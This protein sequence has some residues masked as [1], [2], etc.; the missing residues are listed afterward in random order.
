MRCSTCNGTGKCPGDPT[1][2][3]TSSIGS[4][5]NLATC[6]SCGEKGY[7][8][9]GYQ[10]PICGITGHNYKCYLCGIGENTTNHNNA[11]C[12]RCGGNGYRSEA[13]DSGIC[14]Y[15]NTSLHVYKCSVCRTK[16]RNICAYMG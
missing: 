2:N 8:Y 7:Y 13:C 14:Q 10:C 16:S 1:T 3:V 12:P 11:S 6:P 4:D 5:G 9:R 15:Y